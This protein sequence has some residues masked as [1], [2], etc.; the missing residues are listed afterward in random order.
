MTSRDIHYYLVLQSFRLF[1]S[2]AS[3]S[4][5]TKCFEK[6]SATDYINNDDEYCRS[7]K[8]MHFEILILQNVSS[9]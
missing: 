2:F 9:H 1:E 7:L 4:V 5:Q 3:K 8:E 6:N